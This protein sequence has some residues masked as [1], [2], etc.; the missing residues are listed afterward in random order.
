MLLG[1]A[2]GAFFAGT[3]AD[4]FGRK[5]VLIFAAVLFIISAWG[6][7]VANSTSSF[8]TGHAARRTDFHEPNCDC[9]G[10]D[11]VICFQLLPGENS[12]GFDRRVLGRSRSM[13]LDVLD[14][15]NPGLPVP[16]PF[17]FHPEKPAL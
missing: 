14:G 5:Y 6:S 4:K 1:S 15:I 11:P 9:A 16:V 7:G 10:L 3:L 12:R 8:V 2:V 13:A 17:V